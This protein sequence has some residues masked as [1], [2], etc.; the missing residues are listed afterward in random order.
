ME[1]AIEKATMALLVAV[2][3][4]EV[5]ANEILFGSNSTAISEREVYAWV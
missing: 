3:G 5:A 1:T 4:F 2:S